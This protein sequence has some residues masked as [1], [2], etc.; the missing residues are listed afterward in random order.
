M[1]DPTLCNLHISFRDIPEYLIVATV[2]Y[3]LRLIKK[4]KGL[5]TSRN[6]HKWQCGFWYW[7][8]CSTTKVGGYTPLEKYSVVP[9]DPVF[10]ACPA[11]FQTFLIGLDFSPCNP[12]WFQT[13][14]TAGDWFWFISFTQST[15]AHSWDFLL[16]RF[17][18]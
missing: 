7:I 15:L 9:V 3:V 10:R 5:N 18:I 11:L 16:S 1:C 6:C 12:S 2:L 17:T 8:K 4:L 13:I 14:W